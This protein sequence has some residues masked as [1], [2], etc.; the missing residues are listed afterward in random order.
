MQKQS[1]NTTKLFEALN[2]YPW[3][4]PIKEENMG[5]VKF[6]NTLEDLRD[7]YDT[8]QD[9][10]EIADLSESERKYA[11]KLVELCKDI[12]DLEIDFDKAAVNYSE[13][14]QRAKEH[15]DRNI[16]KYASD[17]YKT[18]DQIMSALFTLPI[19]DG[20]ERMPDEEYDKIYNYL[21]KSFPEK[22][23]DSLQMHK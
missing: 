9:S 3:L 7:C 12:A 19:F 20:T 6:E 18:I 11:K 23:K 5:Y 15:V 13:V 2:P 17:K 14:I 21:A 8:L 1:E 22:V 10:N 4:Q 16:A